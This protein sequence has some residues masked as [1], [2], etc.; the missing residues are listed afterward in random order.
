MAEKSLKRNV[1]YSFVKA[2]MNLAFPLV[3]FP[4]A[5][6]ILFADGIGKVNFANSLIEY[7]VLVASLG[8][9][10]Y[11]A[12]E[13]AKVR[14]DKPKLNKL[15]KEIF[16]INLISTLAAYFMLII[17]FIFIRKFS[18]YKILL[19]ICS[20]KILFTTLGMD[21]LY[22]AHEEFK[23][24]TI[25]SVFFQFVSL[26]MLFILVRTPEDYPEYAFI[27]VFASVGS[28]FCNLLYSRKFIDFFF[29]V[30]LN[31]GRHIRPIFI[32][33]GT[34]L[35]TKLHTALD[36]VMLGFMLNDISVGHYSAAN[37]IKV[38]VVGLMGTVIATL[39]PR[40]SYY[41][42]KKDFAKYYEVLEKTAN[43]SFFFA[44]P[45]TVGIM[46]ISRPLLLIFSGPDFLPAQDAMIIMS[47]IIAI[48][49]FSSVLNNVI[50]TPQRM[51]RYTLYAQIIGCVLNIILNVIFIN[52]WGVF[53]AALAT[54]IVEIVIFL[55]RLAYC[56][57]TLK[58]CNLT[59]NFL[60]VVF[61]TFLMGTSVLLT[62]S[63]LENLFLQILESILVG[64]IVYAT[65]H[66]IMKNVVIYDIL[67]AV[68]KLKN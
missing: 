17:A 22:N 46:L 3:S 4:Y 55:Y 7:F 30:K 12:R 67:D 66:L 58:N 49:T 13:A 64:C 53:G 27:G 52:I 29:K 26:I 38:L 15:C 61:A 2:F 48:S 68:I 11:A 65:V 9:G 39:M 41:I 14:D 34:S 60:Q 56:M 5:S 54:L 21:W 44:I 8:I 24:I 32:F 57:N 45:A 42:E 59:K 62:N 35:A 1:A 47:P 23:Y 20:T 37:K 28:N 63:L 31:L 16:I 40:S 51:E 50:L 19:V 18:Q 36:S 6:R 25:R 10:G 33:F 43:I